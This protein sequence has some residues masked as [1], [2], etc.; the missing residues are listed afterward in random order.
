MQDALEFT[1]GQAKDLLHLRRRMLHKQGQ[2]TREREA[3]LAKLACNRLEHMDHASDKLA[4]LRQ[5]SAQ[6]NRNGAAEYGYF[7]EMCCAFWTGVSKTLCVTFLV[8][9]WLM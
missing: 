8:S 9:Q 4:E 2:L 7:R 5:W 3:L 6:L 1:D